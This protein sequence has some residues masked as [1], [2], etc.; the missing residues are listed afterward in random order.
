VSG[1]CLRIGLASFFYFQVTADRGSVQGGN[2]LH[3]TCSPLY[4]YSAGSSIEGHSGNVQTDRDRGRSREDALGLDELPYRQRYAEENNLMEF[5][6]DEV[7]TFKTVCRTSIHL[8]VIA[9]KTNI[10]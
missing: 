9:G 10:Y 7:N 6:R 8:T 5:I 2:V 3:P 1:L 4:V